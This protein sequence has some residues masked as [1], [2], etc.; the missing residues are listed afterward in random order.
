MSGSEWRVE[1]SR[2][3]ALPPSLSSRAQRSEV[4][5]LA[6]GPFMREARKRASATAKSEF[7]GRL[8]AASVYTLPDYYI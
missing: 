4:E 2:S 6:L 3:T 5:D 1:G 8:L 7:C